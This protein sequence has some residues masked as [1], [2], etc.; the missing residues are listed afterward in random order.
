MMSQVI[1]PS[2]N[3]IKNRVIVDLNH[4]VSTIDTVEIMGICTDIVDAWKNSTE[5]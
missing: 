3:Y 1:N 2:F 4:T 5:L